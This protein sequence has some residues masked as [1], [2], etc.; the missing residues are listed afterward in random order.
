M[1]DQSHIMLKSFDAAYLLFNSIYS[2]SYGVSNN[3]TANGIIRQCARKY[4]ETSDTSITKHTGTHNDSGVKYQ[5]DAKFVS[6]GGYIDDIRRVRTATSPDVYSY[7]ATTNLNG[8]LTSGATTITVDST[9]GFESDGTLVIGTEH[10]AYTGITGTTFT[11]CTR[12][13]D[14]TTAVAH[15]DND[16]VYQ[17]FPLV[18]MNMNWSPLFEWIGESSQIENTNYSTETSETGTL[19]FNRAFLFWVDQNNAPHWVYPDNVVD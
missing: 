4:S 6:E 3:F 11:G 12:A 14:E 16:T 18:L 7:D 10:I 8:A 9:S 2:F 17:G 13:I 5:L 15:S 1:D 19:Y